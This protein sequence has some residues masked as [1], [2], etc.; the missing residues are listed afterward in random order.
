MGSIGLPS[1]FH[2]PRDWRSVKQPFSKTTRKCMFS[3][4]VNV[5]F[6]GLEHHVCLIQQSFSYLHFVAGIS[7]VDGVVKVF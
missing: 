2:L 6:E 5:G 7:A 4:G 1:S 3:L